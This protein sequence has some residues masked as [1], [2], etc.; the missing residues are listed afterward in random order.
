MQLLESYQISITFAKGG[1][2][3]IMPVRSQT[4]CNMAEPLNCGC[5]GGNLSMDVCMEEGVVHI[6]RTIKMYRLSH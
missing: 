3:E 6:K 4:L 1:S 2:N 5:V